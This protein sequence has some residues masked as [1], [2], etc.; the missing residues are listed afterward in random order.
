MF[1][2]ID[3]EYIAERSLQ[4]LQQKGAATAYAAEF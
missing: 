1:K 3:K 2:D 4:Q